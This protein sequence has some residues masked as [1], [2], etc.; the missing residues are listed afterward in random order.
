MITM[1]EDAM[2]EKLYRR[3]LG[4]VGVVG[5]GRIGPDIA[6]FLAK[7]LDTKVVVVDRDKDAL[8]VARLLRGVDTPDLA[9][10]MNRL[11]ADGRS[12]E[13]AGRSVVLLESLFGRRSAVGIEMAI[14]STGGLMDPDE[15]AVSC[16]LLAGGILAEIEKK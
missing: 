8:D 13:V 1:D 11:L 15:L 2:A 5:S 12:R 9:E 10:R 6:L 4:K 3:N 7:S 16:E 14:R